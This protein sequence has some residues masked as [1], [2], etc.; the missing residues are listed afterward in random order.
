MKGRGAGFLPEH[1]LQ[2]IVQTLLIEVTEVGVG[3]LWSLFCSFL[4]FC[5]A[6]LLQ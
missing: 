5:E 6:L 1:E 3:K 2:S 4:D